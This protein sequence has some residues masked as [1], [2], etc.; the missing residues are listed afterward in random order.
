[1]WQSAFETF[2]LVSLLYSEY[3]RMRM[4]FAHNII[5]NHI[6]TV[7]IT[8]FCSVVI[9]RGLRWSATLRRTIELKMKKTFVVDLWYWVLRI[10]TMISVCYIPF[11]HF[12]Y[13][14]ASLLTWF[15]KMFFYFSFFFSI[16]VKLF[17][18]TR[19]RIYRVFG[20]AHRFCRFNLNHKTLY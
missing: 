8:F 13:C 6:I 10:D 1:M 14:T 4:C 12:V 7:T 3:I 15:S 19:L 16:S 2:L 17:V 11:I 5:F 20:T 9:Q 18:D